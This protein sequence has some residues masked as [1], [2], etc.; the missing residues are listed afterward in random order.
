MMTQPIPPIRFASARG[1]RLAYQ[2]FG[3]GAATIVSIPPMAQ[4]I[5]LAWE[6]PEIRRMLERFGSFSTF[7][8]FDKRGTGASDRRSKVPGIDERVEDL[9][10]VLDDAGVGSAHFY[11]NSEGGPMAILFAVTYPERVESLVLWGSGP[12]MMPAD[13]TDKQRVEQKERHERFIS[14]W[15]TTES[16]VVDGFAP[17]LAG[18]QAFRSWHQRYERSAAST[19]SLRDLLDL[20]IEMDVREVLP[21]VTAPTLV[22]HRKGDRVVDIA[23]G[24]ELADNIPR[25]RLI[26]L[27]GDDHFSYVGDIETWMTEVERFVTGEVS[28]TGHPVAAMP[29]VRIHT[30]GRFAVDVDGVE[31]PAS[32]WGSRRARQLC[33]RLVAARGWPV[34]RDELID[35]LWPN[36]SD[37]RRLSARLSV[38]LSAVRKILHGG[39]IAD[40]ET[41]RL[42][43]DSVSTDIESFYGAAD[44]GAIVASYDGEFLPEDVYE[45]WTAGIRDEVRSRFVSA[46]RR[47]AL[48]SVER[49]SFDEAAKHARN[50]IRVDRFD[51][52]AHRLLVTALSGSGESGEARRAHERWASAMA[53][54]DIEVVPFE[55]I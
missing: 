4:N 2:I 9:R 6:R 39:V 44:D 3:E 35:I 50:L 31:I 27:N 14:R 24:H 10:T 22:L 51:E 47:M 37:L 29:T 38:Q 43:L 46:T 17:S 11:A 5:E 19:E 20:I 23:L 18:D 34:T 40:R 55:L 25:D 49:R 12:S 52:E 7:L 26:E 33:K 45:D 8:H 48:R 41:V 32:A 1:T 13:M 54:R 53:E 30:M 16:P 42:D 15:G 28:S 36:E 21:S